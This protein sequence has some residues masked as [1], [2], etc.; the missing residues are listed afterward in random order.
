MGYRNWLQTLG[1]SAL[2]TAGVVAVGAQTALQPTP[3]LAQLSRTCQGFTLFGGVDA[4][5]R[6]AYCIDNNERRD[7]RARYYLKVAGRVV[8]RDIIELEISYPEAFEEEGG[9]FTSATIEL[10]EGTG[11]GDEDIPIA[12]VVV[13]PETN[14]L[15]IYPEEPIP[16]NTSFIVVLSDVRN[17]NRYG[18]HN[19]NL[20]VMY[21]GDSFRQFVG[22]WALDV[23][24]E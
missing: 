1:L 13:D 17:P 10:R 4:E 15:E 23:A 19:F 20:N 21:Q 6:L 2:A 3:A 16:A 9:Y 11:R 5:Y 22:L 24:A 12:E 18:L 14:L 7:T 8:P